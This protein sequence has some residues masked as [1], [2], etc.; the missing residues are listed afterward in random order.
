MKRTWMFCLML[1][2][3][4]GQFV[5]AQ[6]KISGR[7][8]D[9]KSGAPLAGAGLQ[10]VY[11]KFSTVTNNQGEFSLQINTPD[12]L[13]LSHVGYK[14]LRILVDSSNKTL[15]IGLALR[16]GDIEEVVI[17]TGYYEIERGRTTG[18][19]AHVGS[20]LLHRPIGTNIM[21]RLEGLVP[22]LQ[23]VTPNGKLPQDVRVRG[24]STIESDETPLI[25]LDNF[26]YEGS[27]DDIDPNTIESVTVLRDAAS[28]AIWGARAGNG[29]IVLKT[30]QINVQDRLNVSFQANHSYTQ[31][32]DLYYSPQWLPSPVVMGIEEERYRLG[33][34]TF[35]ADQVNPY[36]VELMR[37]RD[38][39]Q[40]TESAFQMEKAILERTDVRRE[41]LKY[42]YQ[43]ASHAQYSLNVSGGT[44]RYGYALGAGFTKG[45]GE[46]IGDE[47]SRK[48]FSVKNQFRPFSFM[49]IGL[50]MAY[51][52]QQSQN[53][54]VGLADFTLPLYGLSPYQRIVNEEGKPFH[55]QKDISLEYAS[56][57]EDNGLLDW[58]YRPL[59][60]RELTK[61]EAL[62]EQLRFDGDVNFN[63]LKGLNLK[64]AYQYAAASTESTTHRYKDSYY[65]RHLVNQFTQPNGSQV[66]PHNGV[67]ARG[68]QSRSGSHQGRV[69]VNYQVD[70]GDGHV[71][72]ALAGSD[73]REAI[74]QRYP[75]SIL[76]NYHDEYLVGSN[77]YNFQQLYD[78]LPSGRKRIPLASGLSSY[79]TNR[80]LSY[81][82]NFS[83]RY[84]KKYVLTGSLRWDASN[85]FGVKINQ[86]GVPLW[87]VGSSWDIAQ[88]G[89][90]TLGDFLSTLRLRTTYGY[91]GNVNKAVTHH[92]TIRNAVNTSTGLPVA[93]LVNIG[94]P[95]LSWE[96]VKTWNAAVEWQSRNQMFAGSVERYF[97]KGMDLIGD[98]LMDPTT[99]ISGSYKI[100]YASIDSYGWDAEL[101]FK[102]FSGPFQWYATLFSSW[103]DNKVTHFYTQDF[104]GNGTYYLVGTPPY[105][106]GDSK[107]I[108]YSV[109]WNGLSPLDGFPVIMMNGQASSEYRKYFIE[110]LDHANMTVSGVK[111]PR[112]YGSFQS[113]VSWKGLEMGFLVGWKLGHVFRRASM[114]PLGEYRNNYHLDYQKRWEK[115]G[116]ER[117]TIVPAYM[118]PSD[119]NNDTGM[120]AS[121]YRYFDALVESGDHIRLQEVNLSYGLPTSVS[122]KAG[123]RKITL[124]LN[125]RNLG[126]LWQAGPSG[127]DPDFPNSEYPLPRTFTISMNLQF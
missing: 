105:R 5:Q 126:V 4:I 59:D 35:A 52:S 25:I 26:P 97:K 2:V 36:Y 40:L 63:I 65:V 20:E 21:E 54:A 91:T 96:R 10:L 9:E 120:M 60:E 61:H 64:L 104:P 111:I 118:H 47:N 32:P 22:G 42:L 100:N 62:S 12:T 14:T 37:A 56:K 8:Y 107:D 68:F 90:F 124:G 67:L 94:N 80:D 117:Y 16:M 92:P 121:M 46:L 82:S 85:L 11:N 95:S 58:F 119:E 84:Q 83:Y 108:L 53:D 125:A 69:Q 110:Y 89:F 123:I 18:S 48:Q 30:R 71:L 7:V 112:N 70:F 17:N 33:H 66:I 99:G 41:A 103:V 79:H 87:S 43:T 77:Q 72:S 28:A 76:Y 55:A 29:V 49:Q 19:F 50:S 102:P 81:F 109:P 13:I 78:I 38:L 45:Q 73:I 75:G 34:Y 27:L 57:A 74:Q 51:S 114:A 15:Q 101:T 127:L 113:R 115:P 98:A 122:S 116:D 86:K 24:L 23:F 93:A 1:L 106:V 39:G 88:E 3:G 6:T 31:K 44:S